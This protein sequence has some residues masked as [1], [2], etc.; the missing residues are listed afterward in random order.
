M[1]LRLAERPKVVDESTDGYEL[2]VKSRTK[3]EDETEG[4]RRRGTRIRRETRKGRKIQTNEH[5][6]KAA[7]FYRRREVRGT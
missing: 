1:L 6:S 2:R 5:T 4:F 3:L 7:G